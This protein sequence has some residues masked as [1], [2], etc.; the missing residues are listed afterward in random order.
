MIVVTTIAALVA[1]VA[2]GLL[3]LFRRPAD[4][5]RLMRWA[6]LAITV[7]V[8]AALT[9]LTVRDS[10]AAASFLLGVPVI[11]AALPVLAQRLGGRAA[12]VDLGAA[13]VIGIWGLLL[14][15]GGLGVAFLP[16]TLPLLV[17]A[18]LG[19]TPRPSSAG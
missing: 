16:S 8:A 14:A 1:V 10:G 9:P 17:S 13:A 12:L 3:A 7:L 2:V 15:L 11:A 4:P 19:L 18:T 6:A 5:Q